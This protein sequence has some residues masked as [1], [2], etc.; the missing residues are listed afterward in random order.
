MII[1]IKTKDFHRMSIMNKKKV[2]QEFFGHK[3]NQIV[4]GSLTN[5]KRGDF[6]VRHDNDAYSNIRITTT[7]DGYMHIKIWNFQTEEWQ[8]EDE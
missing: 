8:E 5:G 7:E 4:S 3:V 1:K 6:R 2:L